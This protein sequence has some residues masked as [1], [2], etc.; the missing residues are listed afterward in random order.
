MRRKR[1]GLLMVCGLALLLCAGGWSV[2][3]V[4]TDEEGGAFSEQAA[5]EIL[6]I[7]PSLPSA[8][9]TSPSSVE[10]SVE[11]TKSVEQTLA[12]PTPEMQTVTID[13]Y[14]YIGVIRVPSMKIELSVMSEWSYHLLKRSPCRFAGSYLDDTLVIAGHSTARHFVA[15][16]KAKLG[17]RVEF[18]DVMGNVI[19]YEVVLVEKMSPRELDR[20]L[21]GDWDL[22]LFT[23]DEG[24]GRRVAVRCNRV[25]ARETVEVNTG[26]N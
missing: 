21:T 15:L 17:D 19:P 3:N 26:T 14:T 18:V 20:M 24:G 22:T 10:T 4:L 9:E 2:Y 25:E 23:C 8:A 7:V 12:I 5:S 6:E 1:G 13:G 11:S 16:R